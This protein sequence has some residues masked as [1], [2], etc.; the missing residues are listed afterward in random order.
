MPMFTNPEA[1]RAWAVA[2]PLDG[3]PPLRR[4]TPRKSK[5]NGRVGMIPD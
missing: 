2:L 1:E 3:G 4:T 5:D